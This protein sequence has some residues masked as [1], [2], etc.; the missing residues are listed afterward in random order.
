[1]IWRL[2][3]CLRD[4]PRECGEHV[5]E[6][7]RVWATSGSSP[8]MRGAL[9]FFVQ[10]GHGRRIIPANAGSTARHSP[11]PSSQPDHP[12]ECGEHASRPGAV[13]FLAGSSPRMR[14]APHLGSPVVMP[15]RIIPANAGSTSWPPTGLQACGDHPRE[16]G[17]HDIVGDLFAGDMG[18]SPR[19]RGAHRIVG[20]GHVYDGIIPANAGS[21][22]KYQG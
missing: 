22:R 19:M 10:L 5:P 8:R 3:A 4:H 6:D 20:A 12:R 18:S 11:P 15:G 21:T 7:T 14:G 17:E 13:D 1:M 9:P 16:C 2:T